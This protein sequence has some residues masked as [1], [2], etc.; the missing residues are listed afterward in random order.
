MPEITS[1]QNPHIKEVVR[2]RERRQRDR[3]GMMLVEGSYE[4]T[5]ALES[6]I[7]PREIYCCQE[8]AMGHPKPRLKVD[9]IFVSRAVFEKIS[10]RDRPDGWLA[11]VP[12]PHARIES[13]DPSH[14]PLLVLAESVEKPGNLGAMLRTAD[15]AGVD[16]LLVCDP[17]TDLYNPNVV[18]ASRGTL[19]SVRTAVTKNEEA[20]SWLKTHG[21][22]VLAATPHTAVS[23]TDVDL[24]QPVCLAVGTED[25]GLT[26]YWME[27]A[28]LR[29]GIP[30]VGKVNSLNVSTST[31]ILLYEAVRQR[32]D[33][34]KSG[35]N[36][37]ML[38]W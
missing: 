36:S 9:P 20:F 6:G 14:P 30:M 5:L 27:R 16:A 18:R 4:L 8:L 17:R 12:I 26:D 38:Y 3:T 29:V 32:R 33:C 31:A 2:L 28:D 21:I 22:L 35:R 19:F 7:Q 15:A 24:C 11:V 23:Y 34:E 10:Y 37:I 25:D 13:I 1:P